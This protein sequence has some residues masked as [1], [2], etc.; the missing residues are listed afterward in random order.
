MPSLGPY[1]WARVPDG[2]CLVVPLSEVNPPARN[3]GVRGVD[4]EPA[5]SILG[6]IQRGEPLP[7][8][9]V[10]EPPGIEAPYRYEVRDGFHRFHLSVGLGFS[11]LPVM[12]KPY[13]SWADLD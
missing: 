11:H 10:H 13:F 5:A 1:A 8:I 2:A 12:V 3:P 6:A 7:P 4:P 9:E